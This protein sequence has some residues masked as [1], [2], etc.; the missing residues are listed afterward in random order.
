MDKAAVLEI[1]VRFEKILHAKRIEVERIVLFGSYA[2]GTA[3]EG[4]DIDL[5]VVSPSF[6]GKNHWERIEI[7]SDAIYDLWAPVEAVAITPK[8]WEEGDKLVVLF[9]RE[10]EVVVGG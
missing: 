4:S 10:G 6:E 9:A 3:H 5:I 8:E 1:I 7:L 2:K